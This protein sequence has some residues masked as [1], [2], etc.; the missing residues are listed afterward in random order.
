MFT[1]VSH[2]TQSVASLVL[3]A[4]TRLFLEDPLRL[5]LRSGLFP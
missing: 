5:D 1:K 3:F 2:W 4:F